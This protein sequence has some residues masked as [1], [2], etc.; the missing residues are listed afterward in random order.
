[1]AHHNYTSNCKLHSIDPGMQPPTFKP[2]PM[3]KSPSLKL[4]LDGIQPEQRRLE[5]ATTGQPDINM[6]T[7]EEQKSEN[8]MSRHNEMSMRNQEE[9]RGLGF[10]NTQSTKQDIDGQ[11]ILSTQEDR[12]NRSKN[13]KLLTPSKQR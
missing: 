2:S 13:D 4:P 5:Y 12:P 7:F 3:K 1:M 10:T 8:T 9:A 6:F 11:E